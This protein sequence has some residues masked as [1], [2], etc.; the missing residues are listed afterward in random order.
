MAVVT[1]PDVLGAGPPALDPPS[2][3]V[4]AEARAIAAR[5]KAAER[6][7][8]SRLRWFC[9]D[10]TILAPE[11]Y[12][13][14]EHGGGRQ[15]AEY[16]ADRERLAALGWPVGTILAAT[17]WQELYDSDRRNQRLRML[18]VE[19]YLVEVD[20]GWVLRRAKSYRGRVQAEDEEQ[21][22]REILLGLLGERRWASESFLL[23]RQAALWLPHHGGT[24]RTAA[25]RT[26]SQVIA[27]SDRSFEPLRIRIH[28]TPGP[29]DAAAVRAWVD[30]ARA[31]G[32]ET[33]LLA[34]AEAL[35][36]D[37]DALYGGSRDRLAAVRKRLARHPQ[38][39]QLLPLLDG[40]EGAPALDR[41]RRLAELLTSCR[42]LLASPASPAHALTLLDVSLEL[43]PELVR[44]AFANSADGDATRFE[45][46]E[47]ARHLLAGGYGAG[48]LSARERD[49]AGAGLA[50]LGPGQV[51]AA[52]DWATAI[53]ELRRAAPWALS[54][55]RSTFAEALIA[56]GALEPK[57][58]RFPDEVLRGS[59]LLPLAEVTAVLSGD[60]DATTGRSH[61][62]FG[63]SRG[64]LAGLNPGVARGR[65]R[66][67]TAAELDRDAPLGRDEIVAL[68]H[69][70]SDLSP[71]AGILSLA[72]GN[73]LS[74]VQLLARNLGIPNVTLSP[75]VAADLTPHD[76]REV[77]LAVSGDGSVVL[78]DLSEVPDTVLAL[79]SDHARSGASAKV[80]PPRAD[81]TVRRPIPLAEL[82]AGMAGRVVGPKAANL[83]EL[84]R[85]FPGRVAPAIALPFGVFAD[86]VA[87]GSDSPKAWLDRAF[88]AHR[89]GELDQASLSAE[90]E[91]VRRAVASVPLSAALRAQLEPMMATT[92]GEPGSY[93]L[94]IRSDTNVEDLPQ[95]TGAGLNETLPNVVDPKAQRDGIARVWA[96]PF[97]ARAMAWRAPVLTRPE[98]VYT[99]VLLMRAVP[100]DKSGVLVT[101][102]LAGQTSGVT[103]AVSWGVGGAVDGD[104]AE[105]LVLG[106]DGT[107]T[108]VGEAKA[109][110]RRRLRTGG[111]VEWVPA[112]QGAVLG[113][114]EIEAV[115]RMAA[116]VVSRLEPHRGADG[117]PLPWDVELGFV[118]GEITLFQVRPLVERGQRLADRVVA[119]LIPPSGGSRAQ[120]ELNARP[121][122]PEAQP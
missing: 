47:L 8:Y 58:H 70:M 104:T 41:V 9:N 35:A 14:R 98:E 3:Q 7:P 6:G 90:V 65:L 97:T 1:V 72:E 15:H 43:E 80:E 122:R 42:D 59:P 26:A 67:V 115:R 36:A 49:A 86:H 52:D 50:R 34:A 55:V 71:V 77:L 51:V 116:E 85:T 79:L 88:A 64:G 119:D 95:F 118:A 48:L 62:V 84:A 56:A 68:P 112:P 53:A 20:D 31:R 106:D 16:S 107:V 114:G 27:E 30:R 113:P 92:F 110:Y 11:P 121:L 111:G 109:P 45:L 82:E 4:L 21:A 120:V 99:S 19:R 100:S 74:H 101:T 13:C 29:T 24:E 17:P 76:G 38:R 44:E 25:V 96:S 12:A 66:V 33:G 5:M 87:T 40:L 23:V 103:V 60:A 91:R 108:L 117:R 46:A 63:R 78:E 73:L 102:N 57:A 89:A 94:F 83:G 105:T 32:A 37:L 81:L 54:T 93:G 10:G 2:E 69:T 39:R 18:L 28:T 61:R 75:L 22:G